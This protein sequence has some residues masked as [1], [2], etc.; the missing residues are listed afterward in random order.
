MEKEMEGIMRRAGGPQGYMYS[1]T[2]NVSGQ[3]PVLTWGNKANSTTHLNK[4]AVWKYG[5]TSS[6]S[7]RYSAAE[8]GRIGAGGVTPNP[9]VYGNQIQIKIAEKVAIYGYFI[10][11]GHLPPGNKIFR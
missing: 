8:L 7:D 5:E 9:L 3:Y 4:D 6:K 1:L 11:N 10:Q 2:A